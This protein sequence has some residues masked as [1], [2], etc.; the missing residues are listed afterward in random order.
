[1]PKPGQ[2]RRGAW[3]ALLFGL[4]FGVA[5][6]PCTFG[7]MAPV[8]GVTFSLASSQPVFAYAVLALFGLG[9]C[10]VIGT[11]GVSTVWV[12]RWLTWQEGTPGVRWLR[13]A[14]GLAVLAAGG[15]LVWSV[16]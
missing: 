9:H 10:A 4:V 12:Q 14:C 5:L 1:M 15:W 3:G 8:L 16:G 11:A 6:G 7:F 2:P 13:R